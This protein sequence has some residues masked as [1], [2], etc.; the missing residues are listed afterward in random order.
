MEN[1]SQVGG[2]LIEASTLEQNPN[3]LI[4]S[5]SAAHSLLIQPSSWASH[6]FHGQSGSS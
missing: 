1:L 3:L 4:S 6:Q 2:E 5:N